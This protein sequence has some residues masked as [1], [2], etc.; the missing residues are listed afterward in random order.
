VELDE[1][2]RKQ[3]LGEGWFT[4]IQEVPLRAITMSV[5]QI[6]KSE[7][8]ICSVPDSR[9][10]EAVR[11]CF[12]SPVSNLY[13]A[14]ILQQHRNCFCYLDKFSSALLKFSKPDVIR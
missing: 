5:R 4:G 2:C 13:P 14:G 7:Q 1:K 10:A 9:K 3:Q 6:L 11:D 12:G 8:I